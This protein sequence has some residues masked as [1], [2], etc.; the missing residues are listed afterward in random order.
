MAQIPL[1]ITATKTSEKIA[2]VD[3]H[4][5]EPATKDDYSLYRQKKKMFDFI[6]EP[7]TATIE[8]SPLVARTKRT[9][10]FEDTFV[11][12]DLVTVDTIAPISLPATTATMSVLIDPV[13][14][15]PLKKKCND[16]F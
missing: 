8:T 4:V 6:T 5:Q 13:L 3:S 12:A 10:V 2:F 15:S 7:S 1:T 16:A 9:L 11:G 14:E